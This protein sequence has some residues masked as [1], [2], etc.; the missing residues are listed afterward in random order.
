MQCT[1]FM[2]VDQLGKVVRITIT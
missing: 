1:L 2:K